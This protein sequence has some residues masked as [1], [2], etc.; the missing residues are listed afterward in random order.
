MPTKT[1][2]EFEVGELAPE[3]DALDDAGTRHRLSAYRGKTVVL[4]FY[5]RDN[6]PGCTVEACDFRDNFPA[7]K[8][9]GAVILGVSGDSAKSHQNFRAKHGLNF[10]LLLDEDHALGKAYGVWGEKTLYGRKFM[11]IIRST[12]VIGKDGKIVSAYRKVSVAG[13]IAA[14]LETI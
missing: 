1:K 6:T 10:P 14:V 2:S 4:Y 12:F 9:K 7:F 5:P 11:G 13:H 8:K 3:F